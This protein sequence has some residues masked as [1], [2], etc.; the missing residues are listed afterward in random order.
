MVRYIYRFDVVFQTQK[1][2]NTVGVKLLYIDEFNLFKSQFNLES[3]RKLCN[4]FDVHP[5]TDWQYKYDEREVC[6][7]REDR[8]LCDGVYCNKVDSRP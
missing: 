8:E 7:R 4:D 5:T 6:S 3:Y 1:I 2:L